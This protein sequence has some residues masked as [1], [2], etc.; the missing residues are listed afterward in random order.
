MKSLPIPAIVAG[1]AAIIALPF[2]VPAA[3]TLMLTAGLGA[4]I[5]ADYVQRHC[6]VRL[7]RRATA[8]ARRNSNSRPPLSREAHQLAA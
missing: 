3:G 5:H 8:P 7:P 4:I 1:L 2:S 6:H